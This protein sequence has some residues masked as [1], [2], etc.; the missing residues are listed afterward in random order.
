MLARVDFGETAVLEVDGCDTANR[1]T[2]ARFLLPCDRVERLPFFGGPRV[3]RPRRWQRAARA[4]LAGA[5]PRIDSLRTAAGAGILIVPF[6]LEPALAAVRGLA[7]R[8][9]IADEV[10]LGKTIQAG[11]IVAEVLARAVDG[12]ALVVCPASL[13]DQWRGE[14]RDRFHLDAAVLDAASLASA[15]WTAAAGAHPWTTSPV[16][17]TSIDFVKRLEVIR[18]LES[19]VWD[20][21][22]LDE[23]HTLSGAS[24][25][26][27]AA[28][29]LARRSRLVVMLSATPHSGD[30][31]AF[32][33]LR[34]LGKLPGDPPLLI[35]RR[36]R[37]DVG[38]PASRRTRWLRVRS[39]EDELELHRAL[40]AYAR[41]VWRQAASS[42]GA[43]LAM[44]V[45]VKRACSSAAS[46]GR[47][48]EKRLHLLA[49]PVHSTDIQ[50]ALPFDIA[51]SDDAE[52]VALLAAPG[53]SDPAEERRRLQQ[54]LELAERARHR[55]SKLAVLQRILRRAAQ[56]V[57]VFTEYRDTLDHIGEALSVGSP[58][59]LHGGLTLRERQ[60]ALRAFT[61][62]TRQVLLATDTAS[63]GLNLHY[64]CRL[65]INMELPWTPL[66][67]EQR[68]GRVDRI[69]QSRRVHAI[70]L[71]AGGTAEEETVARLF[72][73]SEHASAALSAAAAPA[74][75]RDV[76]RLVMDEPS[77][78]SG[79][80]TAPARD[81]GAANLRESARI[82][83]ERLLL[84]RSLKSADTAFADSPRPV[85][86]ARR[87]RPRLADHTCCWGFRGTLVDST[88]QIFWSTLMALTAL[89]PGPL[90]R[91]PHAVRALLNPEQ[92]SLQ[93]ALARAHD[94]A[95]VALMAGLQ[96]W[97]T[98]ALRRE[99]DIIDEVERTRARLALR[100]PGLFDHRAD[101]AALAQTVVLDDALSRCADRLAYLARL[102]M[103]AR[104][105]QSLV[106]AIVLE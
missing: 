49:E 22:V 41:Q 25:R 59:R 97:L 52:P 69:G 104:G 82:E 23:A 18:A 38:L 78:T 12:H 15:A 91:T 4:A 32:A 74:G 85:I 80:S 86:T 60:E 47:S 3:V 40:L 46:A 9:L 16:A 33:R 79:P 19:I 6:Q 57:I 90:S 21:V 100:Q 43:R 77:E 71:V 96:G 54:L 81:V 99:R 62:G 11:L 53:L 7:S 2:R 8:V 65:V 10:G 67:L 68:I 45:L 61:T 34:G 75:E 5:V 92:P 13:R 44:S 76:A 101:R 39:T 58:L 88:G 28:G 93:D 42:G 31:E 17:I 37:S 102:R 36:T 66:R 83:G 27:H 98:L 48:I 55:E 56:P 73:R 35:F 106:F 89:A 29:A 105:A 64:R 51:S 26:A 103:P 95:L 63:E 94:D 20:A 50:L 87:R 14:L 70:H 72:R 84:A 30:D 1:S 24:E